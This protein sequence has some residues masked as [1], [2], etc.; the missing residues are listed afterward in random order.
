[1]SHAMTFDLDLYLQGYLAAALPMLSIIFICGTN[2]TQEGTMCHVPFPGQQ[3]KVTQVIC[4]FAV[5][6]GGGVGWGGV[7][8]S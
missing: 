7:A 4:I 5:G 1:M 6:T 2:T 3:V 8:G